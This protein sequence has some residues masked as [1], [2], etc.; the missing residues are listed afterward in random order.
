M[1]SWIDKSLVYDHELLPVIISHQTP[2]YFTGLIHE[3]SSILH[4]SF[5]FNVIFEAKICLASS[6][7]NRSWR[8]WRCLHIAFVSYGIW[9]DGIRKSLFCRLN[10]N[11]YK[12][13]LSKLRVNWCKVRHWFSSLRQ[14]ALQYQR[15][16]FGK[17]YRFVLC[18]IN[19]YFR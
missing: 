11:S 7:H 12:N 15:T 13:S 19:P 2:T 17:H 18:V 3:V 6:H 10:L 14:F 5:R 4:G 9:L 16:K 1:P 8:M